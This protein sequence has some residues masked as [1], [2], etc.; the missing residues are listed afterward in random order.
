MALPKDPFI[1]C[2]MINM[3]LRDCY[4]SLD[5]LCEDMNEDKTEI[6]ALLSSAG[7]EYNEEQNAFR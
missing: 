3:K 4:P 2:S 7:F 5:A 6:L 1:L